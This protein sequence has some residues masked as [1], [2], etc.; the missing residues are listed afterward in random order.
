MKKKQKQGLD[1]RT[2]KRILKDLKHYRAALILSLVF[3]AFTV[4][5]NLYVPLLTGDAI[6]LMLG[7][8]NVDFAKITQIAILIAI[9]TL[10]AALSQWLMNLLN[11]RITYGMVKKLRRDA[12]E[13]LQKMPLSY[14]D[15]HAVGEVVS[16]MISDVDQFADGLLMGFSQFFTGILTILGTLVIMLTIRPGVALVVI[17][18]TPLSLFV[19][20][21]IAKRT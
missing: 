3:A 11:N 5:L 17:L 2:V 9:S 15:G 6:D 7:K 10:I 18:V 19:A 16:R 21:F 1:L 13:K 4:A 8:G 12:F 20:S 14:I